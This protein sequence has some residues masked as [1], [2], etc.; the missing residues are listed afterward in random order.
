MTGKTHLAVGT[1]VT[2][3]VTQPQNIKEL[4]LCLGITSI[5][6]VISDIDASTSES[7]KK[8]NNTIGIA[9]L[10]TFLCVCIE[11]I[12][13][14]GIGT[15]F[16]NNSNSIRLIGGIGIFLIVCAFGKEQPHRSF[17]HS[18]PAVI[19]LTGIVYMVWPIVAPFFAVSMLSHILLDVLNYTNVRLIYPFK[20][21]ISLDLCHANGLVNKLLF[22]VGSLISIIEI[23]YWG[24]RMV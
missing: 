3:F 11:F 2:L 10:A 24:I 21:G 6:S 15:Y 23:I 22:Q 5:G 7:H 20:W 1:A 13:N 9:V 18:I 17:M 19:S 4:I 8:V 16:L 14:V 12:W